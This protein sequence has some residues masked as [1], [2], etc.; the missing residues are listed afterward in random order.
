MYEQGCDHL[1]IWRFVLL[2]GE[3]AGQHAEYPRQEYGC[4]HQV[5]NKSLLTALAPETALLYWKLPKLAPRVI[6]L[7]TL[8]EGM[9]G[10]VNTICESVEGVHCTVAERI[11]D[12]WL[13]DKGDSGI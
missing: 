13:G 9:Y 2:A 8:R 11:H 12:P 10:G 5:R 7:A 6:S 1:L 3:L 4:L